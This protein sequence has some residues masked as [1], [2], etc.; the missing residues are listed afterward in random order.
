MFASWGRAYPWLLQPLHHCWPCPR[1]P[2]PDPWHI[3][4]QG[5]AKRMGTT[6]PS[7][8]SVQ[9]LIAR[10]CWKHGREWGQDVAP[11]PAKAVLSRPTA[12][13]LPAPRLGGSHFEGVR[14]GQP[15]CSPPETAPQHYAWGERPSC[16][17]KASFPS[18]QEFSQ[19]LPPEGSS[20]RR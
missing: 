3:P 12:R 6:Q 10:G 17:G 8:L 5:A 16:A 4:M 7:L 14:W 11:N 20:G 1:L 19:C 9:S 2:A 13:L 15:F 18:S